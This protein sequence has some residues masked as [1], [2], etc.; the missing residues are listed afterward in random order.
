MARS[1]ARLSPAACSSAPAGAVSEADAYLNN[2]GMGVILLATCN[3]VGAHVGSVG[4][5][6]GCLAGQE[7]HH[8]GQALA[9]L[10][11]A[12]ASPLQLKNHFEACIVQDS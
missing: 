2:R 9:K 5:G 11:P 4:L 8:Q 3:V 12:G 10:S 1:S 7:T 6:N